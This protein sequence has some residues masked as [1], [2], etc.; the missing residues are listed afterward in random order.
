MPFQK[1]A[2]VQIG[3]FNQKNFQI[4]KCITNRLNGTL[5]IYLL[6]VKEFNLQKLEQEL[7]EE[8]I[9]YEVE[10]FDDI[11]TLKSKI[12][13][14]NP[15]IVILTEEKINPLKHIFTHTSAEKLL[16]HIE[17][18]NI[19]LLQENEDNIQKALIYVTKDSTEFYIK[20]SYE[21]V[22]QIIGKVTFVYS[23]FEDAYQVSI[24]KTHTEEEAEEILEAMFDEKKK[25]INERIKKAI[26]NEPYKLITILGEPKK[27][28]NLF[29]KSKGYNFMIVSNNVED[30]KAL[31]ENLQISLGIFLDKEE[32]K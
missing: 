14:H 32:E 31:I 24:K 27:D 7:K 28:I 19:I 29:A 30:K 21:F 22:K 10:I 2:F 17:N 25:E 5:Y 6:N 3:K 18:Y 26:N 11:K 9:H 1:L 8:G 15:D 20:N 12:T 4:V 13:E 23:F 16:K